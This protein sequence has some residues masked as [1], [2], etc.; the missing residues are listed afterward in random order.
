MA[1]SGRED[2]RSDEELMSALCRGDRGALRTL[3]QRHAP[4]L[5][6]RLSRR[7]GDPGIVD[8][9][10]QDTFVAVWR[11]P[12][13]YRG[14]GAVPAWIWG[15][16]V[17]RLI[18]Q[19]RRHKEPARLLAAGASDTAPSAEDEALGSLAH[20]DLAD[21]LNRLSPELRAVVQATVV[22]GLTTREAGRLLGIPAGTVKTRM[23]RAKPR[24]REALL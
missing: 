6:L 1:D 9:S 19:L 18:D 17:R 7:C 10:V 11:R 13:G 5:I 8:E 4:W 16:A 23:M 2:R 21:A 14:T 22:D 20:G 24:L 15:I 12:D 3:H